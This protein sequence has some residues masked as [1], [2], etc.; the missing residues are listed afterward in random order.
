MRMN[1]NIAMP[2]YAPAYWYGSGLALLF[3]D[4]S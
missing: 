3:P 4:M 2:L 1:S